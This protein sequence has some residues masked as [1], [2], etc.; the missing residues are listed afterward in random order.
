MTQESPPV[1]FFDFDGTLT[2]GDTLMP[3]LKHVVGSRVYYAKLV[4]LSPVLAGY[5]I[6]LMRNDVAKQIVL[7]R[8]LTGYTLEELSI[9]GKT[10]SEEIIPTMIRKEGI[11]RLRWHQSQGH[12]CVL[13]SASLDSYLRHW[14]QGQGFTASITSSLAGD[15]AGIVQGKVEG[16]NCYGEEKATRVRAWLESRRPQCSYAYGDS[17]GDLPLL[18][19]ADHGFLWSRRARQFVIV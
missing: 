10:F 13:V 11:T 19:L 5:C 17:V 9:W 18:S 14:A 8:Y 15:A 16:R 12:D 1:A 2:R 7:E 3:F 6:K 4:R